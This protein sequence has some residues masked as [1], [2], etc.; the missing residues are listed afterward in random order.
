MKASQIGLHIKREMPSDAD[1]LAT[2]WLLRG[3]YI[4]RH[5]AGV[6]A[7]TGL[8]ERIKQ[9]VSRIIENEIARAGGSQITLPILQSAEIWKESG[10][11]TAYEHEGLMFQ[12]KDRKGNL[13][14]LSPTAEEAVCQLAKSFISSAA[15][16]P[17]I[18]FQHNTK[19]RDE[20]RPR[21]GLLRSREFLMM[22]AYSFDSDEQGLA[23]SYE[24]MRAAYHAIFRMI[25][26]DYT[27]VQA[28]SGTIGGS[29][30]EEFMAKSDIGEDTLLYNDS[31]AANVER[32]VSKVRPAI[33]MPTGDMKI[34]DLHNVQSTEDIAQDLST[35]TSAI[36][37]SIMVDLTEFE[38]T[39]QVLVLI[40]GDCDINFHKLAN[41]FGA[42]EARPSEPETVASI[43]GCS[44]AYVGP[45][46]LPSDVQMIGDMSLEGN[47]SWTTG[48]CKTEKYAVNAQLGRDFTVSDIADIRLARA[49]EMGPNNKELVSCRGIEVGH[50]FKLGTKYSEPMNAGFTGPEQTI[51]NFQMGCYGIGT[52]RI[53][54]TIADQ[55]CSEHHGIRWPIT[56]APFHVHF[57]PLKAEY[58]E[59]AESLMEALQSKGIDCLVDD[60]KGSMGSKLMDSDVIGSPLRIVI[61]RDFSERKIEMYNRMTDTT[62]LVDLD[63]AV[64]LISKTVEEALE[65]FRRARDAAYR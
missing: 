62:E 32:A 57:I 1:N 58:I 16:L 30:S 26:L 45:I 11:W 25:G 18:L 36:L 52:S 64:E 38:R 42:L 17:L 19:F 13:F 10:R 21:S 20:V 53:L 6:Y 22:D 49:G 8:M 41:K 24:K 60:R 39:R 5:A 40:R 23:V 28:D 4:Y 43:C 63:R 15:Q 47:D 33:S 51:R 44:S 35:T 61:G 14:G 56:V 9:K 55:N 29:A 54:A 50:I 27:V 12:V 46:G 37:K 3:G 31:Y 34:V 59:E 2:A 65:A 7:L 48:I